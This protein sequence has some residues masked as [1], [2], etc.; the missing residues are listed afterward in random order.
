LGLR[1]WP[2][3]KLTLI[4]LIPIAGFTAAWVLLS[5][6]MNF[7][8]RFQYPILPLILMSWYPLMKDLPRE[9]SLNEILQFS[10]A[11][12]ELALWAAKLG[13]CVYV[14]FSVHRFEVN[15]NWNPFNNSNYAK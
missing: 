12:R 5:E 10:P 9:V 3:L 1:K 4:F 13:L 2:T 8:H 11:Y 6:E 7:M 14:L 15:W